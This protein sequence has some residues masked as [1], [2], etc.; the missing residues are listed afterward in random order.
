M[1]S[2]S[3]SPS[4][5]RER[6][7][8]RAA[9]V[10]VAVAGVAAATLV[11]YPLKHVA[12]V[13]S[14]G[15]VYVLAVVVV[16]MFWGLA[17]GVATAVLSVAAFSFFHLPPVG[18]L[19]LADSG[20]W[21]GLAAFVIVAAATGLVADLARAEAREADQRRREA[22]LAA[23]L[24]RVL[25]GA[26]RLQ[27]ALAI[28]AQ[29]VADAAA[30]ESA[31]IELGSV[32]VDARQ[33]ALALEHDGIAIGTLV[34]PVTLP[35]RERTWLA[36]RVVPS[37]QSILAAALHR[38]ELQAEV[39]ETAALRRSDEMK[40]A[41][42]RSVSHD[43]RTP[44]TT[45]LTAAGALDPERPTPANVGEVR[46]LVMDA[47][48]RLWL[49]IEK[50]LDLSLLQAGRLE[51]SLG[52]YS[53]E[54]VLREAIEQTGRHEAFRLSVDPELPLLRGDPGQLER[55]FANV[56]ENGAR[57]SGGKPVS[58]RA[59]LVGERVR[60]RV[61]DQGPGI[62]AS[63]HERVFLPFYRSEGASR[64]HHGSGLGLAI[65]KGFVEVNG[66]RIAVESVPG[67]GTSVVV[68]FPL[69]REEVL[70]APRDVV[71][72]VGGR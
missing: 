1:A 45:I 62:E 7:P 67:Q 68:E 66:G 22:D 65:A 34:L 37:L 9:G 26:T 47:G 52:L 29:R 56:L 3:V 59:R 71:A 40:T 19:T 21:I 63:E 5:L 32:E 12:P 69:S 23:E 25:L 28:A 58:V 31:V 48:T 57:Y 18:R 13:V 44:V 42:L 51:P 15:V 11:V 36:Q 8:S 50:L 49:L 38:T 64:D 54:E 30:V 43:L 39:V 46:E 16:S 24:A 61:V 33:L 6:R 70:P 14:L 35:E 17:F 20:N 55:A 72:P 41:V 10:L 53:I 60:V 4:F 2:R 27:D